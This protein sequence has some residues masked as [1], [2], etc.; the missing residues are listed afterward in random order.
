VTL[1]E[2]HDV[3]AEAATAV[4]VAS[5]ELEAG[6]DGLVFEALAVAADQITAA[7]LLEQNARR[8]LKNL[9]RALEDVRAGLEGR[10]TA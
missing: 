8:D 5:V 7:A 4:Q 2:L 9:F 1:P 10:P 6:H 3:L